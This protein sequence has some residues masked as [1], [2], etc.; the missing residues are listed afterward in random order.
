MSLACTVAKDTFV[1]C[2]VSSSTW[3]AIY[4]NPVLQLLAKY[5]CLLDI[6]LNMPV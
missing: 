3:L 2:P 4:V 5:R 6:S 1:T